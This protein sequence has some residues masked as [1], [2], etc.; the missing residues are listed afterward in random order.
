MG[1]GGEK[2]NCGVKLWCEGEGKKRGKEREEKGE[3]SKR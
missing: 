2:V 3:N 1:K